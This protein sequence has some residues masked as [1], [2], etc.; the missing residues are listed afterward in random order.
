MRPRTVYYSDEQNDDF[1]GTQIVRR[2]VGPDFPFVHRSPLWRA[3]AFFLYYFLA[4][5]AVFVV[6]K[7]WYGMRIRNRKAVRGLRDGFFL[8]G[9]HTQRFADVT[10]PSL[11]AFPKKAY[12]VA[13]AEAVSIR[14]IGWLVQMLGGLILPTEVSGMRGFLQAVAQR[15]RERQAIAVFPEAHIWP[16][17]T[18]I[19]P[20]PAASFDYPVRSGRPAVAFCI[21]YRK[22]LLPFLPPAITV[23]LSEPFYRDPAL[24]DRE[25]RQDLRDRA[26]AF[27]CEQAKTNEVEWIRYEKKEAAAQNG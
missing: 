11:L 5:P 16:Y 17:Y 19:R 4:L 20:F 26:Y 23:T 8:Y 12:V 22:R 2:R 24:G 10:C 6:N 14:G 27:L 1:A 15:C 3:A 9:N 25:A 13:G 18:G 7:L 21:T